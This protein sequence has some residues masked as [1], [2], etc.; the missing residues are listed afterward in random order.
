MGFMNL[1]TTSAAITT[2][3]Q[4]TIEMMF[5][6]FEVFTDDPGIPEPENEPGKEDGR[7]EL[8]EPEEPSN[9]FRH[10]SSVILASYLRHRS[11]TFIFFSSVIKLKSSL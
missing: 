7:E 5:W 1:R 3:K 2:T 4:T 10:S 8:S 9:I 11:L 6:I